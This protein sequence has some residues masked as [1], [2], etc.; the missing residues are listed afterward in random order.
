MT[1]SLFFFFFKNIK[2][3]NTHGERGE[4]LKKIDNDIYSKAILP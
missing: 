1:L 3:F 4:R 2:Y